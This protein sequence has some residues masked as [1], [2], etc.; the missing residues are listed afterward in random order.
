MRFQHNLIA[1]AKKLWCTRKIWHASAL[2]GSSLSFP[3]GFS[4]FDKCRQRLS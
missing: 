3:L 4:C 1:E 2:C